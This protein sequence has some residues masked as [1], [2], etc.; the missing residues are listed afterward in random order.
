MINR[1]S[2]TP[3]PGCSKLTAASVKVSLKFQMR[4]LKIAKI[5]C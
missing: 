2:Y 5:F 3:G 4:Y 1:E